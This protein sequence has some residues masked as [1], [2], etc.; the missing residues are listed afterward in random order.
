VVHEKGVEKGQIQ[1]AERMRYR[2]VCREVWMPAS[3]HIL[4]WEVSVETVGD[5]GVWAR[6][7]ACVCSASVQVVSTGTAKTTYWIARCRCR[8]TSVS[9]VYLFLYRECAELGRSGPSHDP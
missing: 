4:H 7:H 9:V 6:P 8:C 3:S 1:K 5:S 2:L